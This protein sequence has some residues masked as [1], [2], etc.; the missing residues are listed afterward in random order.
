M[1]L[2]LD[3]EWMNFQNNDI[4]E[5]VSANIK[6]KVIKKELPKCSDIYMHMEQ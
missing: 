2:S 1:A 5:E 3:E 4:K 6:Q